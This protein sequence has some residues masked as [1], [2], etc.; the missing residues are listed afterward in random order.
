M[1]IRK[2]ESVPTPRTTTLDLQMPPEV[3]RVSFT[4]EIYTYGLT[5]LLK[6]MVLTA[7]PPDQHGYPI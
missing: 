3:E 2:R 6:I 5:A 4:I 7:A 1:L